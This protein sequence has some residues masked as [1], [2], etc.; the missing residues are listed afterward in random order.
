M[1]AACL[2][3]SPILSADAG[4]A[5]TSG[6]RSPRTTAATTARETRLRLRWGAR[7]TTGLMGR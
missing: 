7:S 6:V 4:E 3:M 5:T 1:R 2:R